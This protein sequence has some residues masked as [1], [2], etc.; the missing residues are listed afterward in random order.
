MTEFL[1]LLFKTLAFEIAII[2]GVFFLL[3]FL[4]FHIQK[5]TNFHY[6]RSIG[7]KGILITA[8]FGTPI[9]EISHAVTAKLFNHTI[10]EIHFF[11]PNKETGGLGHV[12]HAYNPRSVYQRIGNFFIGAA[13]LIFGAVVLLLFLYVFA[14][15]GREVT[16]LLFQP[17]T[18]ELLIKHIQHGIEL[19]FS[20]THLNEWQFWL[21]L[22]ISFCVSSHMAPS[23]QD[24]KNMWK[25]F[26]WLIILLL[27]A[28]I[29]PLLLNVDMITIATQIF[30]TLSFFI[31]ILVYALFIS[32]LHFAVTFILLHIPYTLIKSL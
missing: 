32:L 15:N 26:V 31:A 16:S 7:F 22:Y 21:F 10:E 4:L 2:F 28:N 24:I 25:G 11:R 3:G 18:P 30:S 1:L 20:P 9:H 29:I 23:R 27:F 19:L 5:K 17:F 8:W 13:P 14:P 12:H 6:T